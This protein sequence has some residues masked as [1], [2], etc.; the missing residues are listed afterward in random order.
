MQPNE[1]I[2]VRSTQLEG[3]LF[4]LVALHLNFLPV[5]LIEQNFPSIETQN[6]SKGN[7][8]KTSFLF[9]KQLQRQSPRV[10]GEKCIY[11][12]IYLDIYLK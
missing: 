9:L 11:I 8:C 10:E 7:L 6:S 4:C 1:S 3:E 5:E 12:Y 2:P